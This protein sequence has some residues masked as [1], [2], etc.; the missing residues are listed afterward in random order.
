MV[1]HFD[2]ISLQKNVTHFVLDAVV[3]EIT[4]YLS[5]LFT[6]TLINMENDDFL[7]SICTGHFL[8]LYL[9]ELLEKLAEGNRHQF[10]IKKVFIAHKLLM[11]LWILTRSFIGSESNLSLLKTEARANCALD[12]KNQLCKV[13]PKEFSF[14]EMLMLN[15]YPSYCT[16]NWNNAHRVPLDDIQKKQFAKYFDQQ[17]TDPMSLQSQLDASR[18][19]VIVPPISSNSSEGLPLPLQEAYDMHQKYYYVPSAEGL[20][21]KSFQGSANPSLSKKA[22]RMSIFIEYLHEEFSN[23]LSMLVRLLFYLNISPNVQTEPPLKSFDPLDEIDKKRHQEIVTNIISWLIVLYMKAG[24]RY[25][26][27]F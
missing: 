13:S 1:H 10:P 12:S 23:H 4:I 17:V 5:V 8:P 9:C 15:R 21:D 3:L 26:I 2:S 24:K 25:R 16:S 20:H 19:S 14:H 27:D 18:H 22:V 6:L 11:L 7:D